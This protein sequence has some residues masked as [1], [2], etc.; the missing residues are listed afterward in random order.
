MWRDPVQ[1][2]AMVVGAPELTAIKTL[3]YG[4]PILA[5]MIGDGF[6]NAGISAASQP[7]VQ[8]WRAERGQE[9]GVVPA[10]QDVGMN[11]LFGAA[12]GGAV[13]GAHAILFHGATPAQVELVNRAMS[14]DMDAAKEV[15]AIIP[16][17]H[18]PDLHAF[19]EADHADDLATGG[20]WPDRP[21]RLNWSGLTSKQ[22]I[23]EDPA[24]PLPEMPTVVDR[25]R[26]DTARWRAI[27]KTP[28]IRLAQSRAIL[29]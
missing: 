23:T 9:N 25:R 8:Q 11:F 12:I 26:T 15:A 10:M 22:S 5:R 27:E 24:Y 29:R 6:L 19:L 14:G 1:A 7:A 13:G 16:K 4:G 17:E 20:P 3:R 28:T 18:A 21:I 2:G